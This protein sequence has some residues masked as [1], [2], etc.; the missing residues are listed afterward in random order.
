MTFICRIVFAPLLFQ[1][2][3][4][5]TTMHIKNLR[6]LVL[7]GVAGL[8]IGGQEIKAQLLNDKPVPIFKNDIPREP[9]REFQFLAFFL[10]QGV[11][12][13]FYPKNTLLKGQVIGRMFGQ[14]TT[15]TSDSLTTSYAEQRLLPFFIYQPKLFNG[16]AILRAAFEIDWTWGDVA[17]G[18][19]GNFGSAPSGDQVN[20]QTQNVELELRP[21]NGWAINLG[22][23]RMFDSP[24][25]PYRTTVDQ[26]LNTGYRLGY[27]GTEGVGVTVRKDADFYRFKGGFFKLYESLIQEND[28]V[29][30][31]ELYYEQHVGKITRVGASANY[32]RDRANGAG[33]VSILGQGLNATQLNAYNGTFKFNFGPNPYRSDIFWLGSFFSHNADRMVGRFFGGGFFNYNFGKAEVEI[34]DKWETGADISGYGANLNGGYRFGQT[35]NDVITFDVIYASGDDDA[36]NDKTYNGVI[37]GNMWASPGNVFIGTGAYLL[38]P[39]GNVV[40][41]FTPLVADYSNMGYGLFG[42]TMNASYDVIPHKIN[43]KVGTAYAMSVAEP[44]G[45][46]VNL[47]T[48]LNGN[49]SYNFG[50]FMSVGIHGAYVWLGDFYDS[51]DTRYGSD[52]N[53]EYNDDRPI[54]PWTAFVVFKWLMF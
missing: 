17:Y 26:M 39:H 18:T 44:T 12:S 53:G 13:N 23:Q 43:A 49:I 15:S 51:N 47:G 4:K 22:L 24:F 38:F 46:G 42:G 5:Q 14:N 2:I 7:F 19:G 21:G 30:M 37:T 35:Y 27:W 25:N 52:V 54:N 9:E 48:E 33:G 50:P 32:V 8:L 31:A 36:L 1:K 28:D 10:T 6:K 34:D 3:C 11:T 16:K 29:S 45:G 20:L 40:N 41:R